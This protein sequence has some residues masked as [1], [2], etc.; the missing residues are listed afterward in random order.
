M[1]EPIGPCREMYWHEMD[2]LRKIDKMAEAIVY[3][4][5]KLKEAL[6]RI[7][8]LKDH[9]HC[10]GK[11]YVPMLEENEGRYREGGASSYF[12]KNP[13]GQEKAR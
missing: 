7:D 9:A 2:S 3:L 12:F 10:D 4:T 1:A 13:L 5:A 8:E 6:D 11:I